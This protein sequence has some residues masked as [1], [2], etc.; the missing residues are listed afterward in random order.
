MRRK[1]KQYLNGWSMFPFN[2]LM[3]V[4]PVCNILVICIV[5]FEFMSW[6]HI[7]LCWICNFPPFIWSSLNQRENCDLPVC[8]TFS[9]MLAYLVFGLID[10]SLK[11]MMNDLRM[12]KRL[13]MME[14]IP[15]IIEWMHLSQNSILLSK[16]HTSN[17]FR[18]FR[19]CTCKLFE[20]D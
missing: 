17:L 15:I 13:S 5:H 14:I 9:L 7:C 1:W 12:Q 3:L 18:N 6:I 2:L 16:I 8:I 19:I 20:P 11:S 4:Q 10:S